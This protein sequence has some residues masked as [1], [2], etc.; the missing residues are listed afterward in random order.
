MYVTSGVWYKDNIYVAT[1]LGADTYYYGVDGKFK[2]ETGWF[3]SAELVFK[4]GILVQVI[5]KDGT[6]G[7]T[8]SNGDSADAGT[9]D[10]TTL[11]LPS[12]KNQTGKFLTVKNDTEL[13]W[14]KIYA[15]TNAGDEG[16][17]L[18]SSGSGKDPTW[19]K[20][21]ASLVNFPSALSNHADV[22]IGTPNSDGA[23]VISMTATLEKDKT[24]PSVKVK[25]PAKTVSVTPPYY[26][27]C[28][29]TIPTIDGVVGWE[30]GLHIE[31]CSKG[32]SKPS[33]YK[34]GIHIGPS[35][36]SL[37]TGAIG[38]WTATVDEY[39]L[40]TSGT[41]KQNVSV[42]VTGRVKIEIGAST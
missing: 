36:L 4:K 25:V 13:E 10:T 2:V 6:I 34:Y 17:I 20:L 33:G 9:T 18:I 14:K 31:E 22:T 40:T 12:A 38:D 28:F 21:K 27:I 32:S 16:E 19:G 41:I 26:W 15:P 24:V 3:N 39:D 42:P 8:T 1:A 7:G 11:A 30:N 23:Y 29:N 37:A 5:G 35:D